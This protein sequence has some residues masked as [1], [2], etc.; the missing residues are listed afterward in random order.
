MNHV[1]DYFKAH[2]TSNECFET[3]DTL[4]FDNKENAK[5]HASTLDD[6]VITPWQR[7]SNAKEPGV[8]Q[9]STKTKNRS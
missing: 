2:P 7:T 1:E 5:A 6:K 4:L 8:K 3:S 9:K